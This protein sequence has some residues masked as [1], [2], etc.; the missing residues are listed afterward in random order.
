[1]LALASTLGQAAYRGLSDVE[2]APEL[3]EVS[4]RPLEL[5]DHQL[6]ATVGVLH[7]RLE[8]AGVRLVRAAQQAAAPG[9]HVH[10]AGR[11]A[12]GDA[13]AKPPRWPTVEQRQ[14][15]TRRG[16]QGERRDVA[17]QARAGAMPSWGAFVS[18]H[19]RQS[20]VLLAAACPN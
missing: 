16:G 10:G 14:R 18:V 5:L 11:D 4:D 3:G 13:G 2:P 7:D 9:P 19:R 6:D 15:Q 17:Q 8:L 12:G 20:S 1:M